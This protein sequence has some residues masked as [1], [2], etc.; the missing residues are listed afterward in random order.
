[1]KSNT[2]WD[3]DALR[4]RI[5]ATRSDTEATD[6]I[7]SSIHKSFC[8][9]RYH[10]SSA[11]D[12]MNGVFREDNEE[13][14][15]TL[16]FGRGDNKR[17]T[18]IAYAKIVSEANLICCLHTTRGL[19]DIFAQLLNALVLPCPLAE[20]KC[21]IATVA[22]TLP[23]S[24]LKDSVD[25]LLGSHWY[26]YVSAFVNTTKHRRLVPHRLSISLDEDRAGIRIAGFTYSTNRKSDSFQEY[27]DTEV[28]DG[29]IEVK[30]AIV[31]CGRELNASI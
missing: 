13:N 16:L 22:A 17:G 30:D 25:R 29:A 5:A 11:R 14:L 6:E 15:D 1:M 8:I 26:L 27:W 3:L 2:A 18:Q 19:W 28:L 10:I 23:P 4:L 31:N 20:S 21:D 12:A 24:S 7:I 9:F